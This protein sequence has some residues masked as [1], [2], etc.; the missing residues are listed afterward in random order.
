[1]PDKSTSKSTGT[2]FNTICH[3]CDYD[4]PN[5]GDSIYCSVCSRR[6]HRSCAR[7]SSSA[8][9]GD[10]TW[11]CDTCNFDQDSS[12]A[13]GPLNTN[14]FNAIMAQLSTVTNAITASN[15]K[16]SE[17]ANILTSHAAEISQLRDENKILQQKMIS[18]ENKI[19]ISGVSKE[20]DH[21]QL[22][23]EAT[24]RI[25]REKNIILFGIPESNHS[26]TTNTPRLLK[27]VLPSPEIALPV[28]KKKA[29]IPRNRFPNVRVKP[30]LTPSQN[31]Q[32]KK[33]R[34][35]LNE[36]I[37][38]GTGGTESTILQRNNT[39]T[40]FVSTKRKTGNRGSNH[41]VQLPVRSLSLRNTCPNS[42]RSRHANVMDDQI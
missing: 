7:R 22:V 25:K 6:P 41:S 15:S 26:I 10:P 32:L 37:S 12:T 28:L 4:V 35:E 24:E 30:D 14:H 33:L 3:V 36:R 20:V 17:L 40:T 18:L 5:A 21:E 34:T 16:I 39:C 42:R 27:V 11:C 29:N 31:N 19:S 2:S 23:V 1:M 9:G 8:V 38:K 13:S